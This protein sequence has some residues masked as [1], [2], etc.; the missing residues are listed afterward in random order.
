MEDADARRHQKRDDAQPG[1]PAPAG[2][3][4]HDPDPDRR[5]MRPALPEAELA[6]GHAADVL[7]GES[8]AQE[9]NRAQ[10]G[11]K[12]QGRAGQGHAR[13]T[14]AHGYAPRP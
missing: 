1:Q 8:P 7:E 13:L 12:D 11:E 3:Q 9:G 10:R 6:G 14:K 5:R 4:R 2:R